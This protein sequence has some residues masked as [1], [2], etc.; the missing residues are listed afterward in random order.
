M[1]SSEKK[2]KALVEKAVI[3]ARIDEVERFSQYCSS[4]TY[5]NNRLR[6][7]EDKADRI[8]DQL[9]GREVSEVRLSVEVPERIFLGLKG[10]KSAVNDEEFVQ[11][12]KR[13]GLK[14]VED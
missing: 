7:L 10:K 11:Y 12:L 1:T 5:Y 6:T 3:N 8:E 4:R 13:T 9:D 14:F 2:V